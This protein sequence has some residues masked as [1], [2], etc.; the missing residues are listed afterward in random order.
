MIKRTPQEIADFFGCY[1]TQDEK[2]RWRLFCAKPIIYKGLDNTIAWDSEY[3]QSLL[4]SCLIDV[5]KG[6]NCKYLYEPQKQDTAPHQSEV[7]THKEYQIVCGDECGEGRYI[8][9]SVNKKLSEGWE[10]YGTPFYGNG[11]IYQAMVRGV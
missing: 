8:S 11:Y 2:G 7:H 9:D 5:P 3:E 6:H 1:V 4:I 10:L